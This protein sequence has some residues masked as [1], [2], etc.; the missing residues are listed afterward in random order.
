MIVNEPMAWDFEGS[1]KAMA[2]RW[3]MTNQEINEAVGKKLGLDVRQCPIHMMT[4]CCGR[5][6]IPDY[7]TDIKA[8][9][10]MVESL[11]KEFCFVE[12]SFDRIRLLW[13]CSYDQEGPG[14]IFFATADTAPRAI[15]L[16]F[17]KLL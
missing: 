8:A 12:V 2:R 15:C 13:Q 5:N 1:A 10:E 3:D 11:S 9:W 4:S 14:A 17:L 6:G 7:C 16:A